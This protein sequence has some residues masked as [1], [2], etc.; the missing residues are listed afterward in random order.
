[1]ESREELRARLRA[2]IKGKRHERSG[3]VSEPS[4][5]EKAQADPKGLLMSLGI[6]NPDV[7]EAAARALKVKDVG[8]M[9]ES[10]RKIEDTHETESDDEAPPA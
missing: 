8:Q 7:L 3:S 2:K 4:T 6:D 10:L 5:S 1:M 9:V